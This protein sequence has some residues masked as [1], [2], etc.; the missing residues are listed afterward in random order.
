MERPLIAVVC[1][2]DLPMRPFAELLRDRSQHLMVLPCSVGAALV[3][4]DQLRPDAVVLAGA[5]SVR[6][7]A[8]IREQ[9]QHALLVGADGRDGGCDE[10]LAA[11]LTPRALAQLLDRLEDQRKAS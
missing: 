3:A 11:P 4:I 7:A 2:P 10:T 8:A 6:L 1:D 5:R 9:D